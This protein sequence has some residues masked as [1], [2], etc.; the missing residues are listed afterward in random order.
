MVSLDGCF[1]ST[2]EKMLFGWLLIIADHLMFFSLYKFMLKYTC[3]CVSLVEISIMHTVQTVAEL[4]F[5]FP[6][7]SN[8]KSWIFSPGNFW[9]IVI[10]FISVSIRS[11]PAIFSVVPHHHPQCWH[12]PAS[13]KIGRK[14]A[15][16]ASI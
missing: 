10:L 11:M 2:F 9:F 13:Y 3:T 15:K 4:I 16:C 7:T 1:G 14:I 8:C 12:E 5:S 6:K